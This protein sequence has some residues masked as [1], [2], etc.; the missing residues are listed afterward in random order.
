M[1]ALLSSGDLGIDGFICPG[2]VTTIIGTS[3]YHD[4]A[5]RY[6]VPCVVVGFEPVD[7]LQG[8]LMLVRQIES[9]DARVEIQYSRGASP[10]GNPEALKIM[11]EVFEPCDSRWRGLGLIEKSGLSIRP[12]YEA[13]DAAARFDL[14]VAQAEE[15]RG[16]LC[17][18][19]L[20]GTATPL[21][22]P[23]FRSLCTPRKPVGPC[24]V[25]TEGTCAAYYKYHSVP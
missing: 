11:N 2:H 3:A 7:I 6:K 1:N 14:S 15:P 13:Q 4:I 9:G 12:G 16:C 25:S 23:L 24:M 21:D 8:I 17:A 20:R 19:V 18:Q 10:C 5:R 22:C